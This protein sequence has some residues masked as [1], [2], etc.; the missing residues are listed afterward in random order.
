M[1]NATTAARTALVI[2]AGVQG[3][4]TATVLAEAGW[5]VGIRTDLYP[6]DT[7]SAVAGA[8]GWTGH[9]QP[10]EQ[11]LRWMTRGYHEFLRL[12][13]DS[14]T[15][16]HQSPGR[17]AARF[18]LGDA[19]PEE[20]RMLSDLRACAHEDLPPGFVSGFRATIPTIDMPR[21]L[22][23][24]LTRFRAAGGT[25]ALGPVPSLADAVAEAPVVVNCTGTGAHELVGDPHVYAVRG[26]HVV[27]RNPGIDEY[28]IEIAAGAEFA[29]YVP[30]GDRVV[31]G[32]IAVEDWEIT[33]DPE[34]TAGILRRCA[35]IEPR[36]AGA[37][38]E[39]EL[40]GLR[41][42]RRW[43]RL[44]IEEFE[45]TP[46]VHNYGHGSEGVA[47]SWGSAH[48]AAELVAGAL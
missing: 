22:D 8:L 32:G 28:F 7:T 42:A 39:A 23:Y 15:G 47:L 14:R 17:M 13:E 26:Q 24:L 25:L 41:P 6:A 29:G 9:V 33:P 5:R 27:V 2:G 46:V 45:G 31:C 11:L 36:L 10:S 18:D 34:V 43:V 38:V 48:D 37:E 12:A 21:Y 40:V 3:L 44:D 1:T 35:E 20:A 19:V 4:T 30:H 16:V